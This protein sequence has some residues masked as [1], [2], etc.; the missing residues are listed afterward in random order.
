MIVKL[1][2]TGA[3]SVVC[4]QDGDV[5]KLTIA[6]DDDRSAVMNYSTKLGM[7]IGSG[8]R[9]TDVKSSFFKGLIADILQFANGGEKSFCSCQTIEA[10]KI[11]AAAVAAYN[12]PGTVVPV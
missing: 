10:I 1:I 12:N 8:D 7:S 4:E 5:S 11:R 2:G 9:K 6:Y 3:K